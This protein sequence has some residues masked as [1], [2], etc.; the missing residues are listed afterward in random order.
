[1]NKL[2]LREKIKLECENQGIQLT[3]M[4]DNAK[5]NKHN[6]YRY[7]LSIWKSRVAIQLG[8]DEEEFFKGFE[9]EIKENKKKKFN[10]DYAQNKIKLL[11]LLKE[12]WLTMTQMIEIT[13]KDINQVNRILGSI[14]YGYIVDVKPLDGQK[15]IKKY[16]V[17]SKICKPKVDTQTIPISELPLKINKLDLLTWGINQSDRK[18]ETSHDLVIYAK[19]NGKQVYLLKDDGGY[20][21][22]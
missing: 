1:M 12:K 2:N 17:S 3:K 8:V 9:S 22:L 18:F 15:K 21:Y 19:R 7:F 4:L 11:E 20:R 6:Y 13:E 5:V 16:H 14:K 10:E